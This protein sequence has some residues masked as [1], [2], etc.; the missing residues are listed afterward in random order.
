VAAFA[1]LSFAV[2]GAIAFAV[3]T[4]LLVS[5]PSDRHARLNR[6]RQ[7][8]GGQERSR[9]GGRSASRSDEPKDKQGFS[10]AAR[11]LFRNRQLIATYAL[12][13]CVLFTNVAMFTYVTFHL[14]APPYNLSTA[15]L[16]WLFVVYLLG[17]IVTPFGGRW[18][19]K[20]GHRAGL[21][22][23]MAIGAAGALLTL[24]GP[25]PAIIAGLAFTSTGVFIAQTTTSSYIGAVTT[26]DRGLAVGG[27]PACVALIVAVQCAGALIAFTTW[28]AP[29]LR[30]GEAR[31][32]PL[33]PLPG[34]GA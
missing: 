24:L 17:V 23:A 34:G 6:R 25:L 4:A 27:W 11:E 33:P 12:G 3:A 32:L 18:I 10:R 28:S 22:A 8:S 5:L 21:G 20:H 30:A 31:R 1:C 14:A 16:G 7:A 29:T 19:D 2:L 9:Y 13:F 15:A 26:G